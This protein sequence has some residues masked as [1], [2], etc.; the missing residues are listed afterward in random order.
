VADKYL[1][2]RDADITVIQYIFN[3]GEADKYHQKKGWL[4][5]KAMAEKKS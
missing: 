5:K 2:I 3:P 1:N 4:L